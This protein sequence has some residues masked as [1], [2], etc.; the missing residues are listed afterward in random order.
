MRYSVVRQA[1]KES[2]HLFHI[3]E[4]RW[5]K[6]RMKKL[7]FVFIVALGSIL[8]S[9]CHLGFVDCGWGAQLLTWVDTNENGVWDEGEQPVEGVHFQ[10]NDIFNNYTDVGRIA[11]SD[12]NGKAGTSVWLPGCPSAKFE[13]LAILPEG[14][15]FVSDPVVQIEGRR[16]GSED[17]ILF[18]L[19][20]EAGY[21]TPTAYPPKLQCATFPI[22][23]EDFEI[24]PDG[25]VWAVTWDG[26]ATYKDQLGEWQTFPLNSE[27]MSLPENIDI[28]I[29]G[30]IWI[31]SW[32]GIGLLQNEHWEIIGSEEPALFP[33]QIVPNIN[34]LDDEEL[35]FEVQAPAGGFA[36]FDL[37]NSSWSLYGAQYE[38][39]DVNLRVT[40]MQGGSIWFAYFESD[41]DGE[42]LPEVPFPGWRIQTT[43][44]FTNDEFN[45]V[46][47]ES[48][49][50]IED[51]EIDTSGT[52]WIAHSFGLS[53]YSPA[54]GEWIN[55]EPTG[56]TDYFYA[57][58][59]IAIGPDNTIWSIYSDVHP[60]LLQLKPN[61]ITSLEI[62]RQGN[63]WIGYGLRDITARC[64]T[65]K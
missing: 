59:D 13:V 23:A 34:D 10:V 25:S 6:T 57:P 17:P 55:Y 11:I 62:D 9:S 24:A 50:W 33:E 52:L 7:I 3:Q 40:L 18:P 43:H 15:A 5:E 54:E 4:S 8:L 32:N 37:K 36:K 45:I 51:I 65:L 19:R 41:P 26:G 49:S 46:P 47:I 29:E 28:G 58:E 1:L 56:V 12:W 61:E 16:Y 38:A 27:S 64:K 44:T 48:R 30:D 42:P 14:Y 53:S 60:R 63:I 31:R 39:S 35:W 20:R 2:D 22:G 21:P